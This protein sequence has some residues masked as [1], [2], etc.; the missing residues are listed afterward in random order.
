MKS[1]FSACLLWC[2]TTQ[3]KSDQ[4]QPRW[5]LN[6]RW[7]GRLLQDKRMFDSSLLDGPIHSGSLIE[8]LR[9]GR[10]GSHAMMMSQQRAMNKRPQYYWH[11]PL[12]HQM[13]SYIGNSHLG[14]RDWMDSPIL[15]TRDSAKSP[16]R[17][18]FGSRLHASNPDVPLIHKL[19]SITFGKRFKVPL[20]DLDLR[21]KR[22]AP[23]E[24]KSEGIK[25]VENESDKRKYE[26]Y[27][28]L[29]LLFHR[30]FYA[31]NPLPIETN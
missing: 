25:N 15:H 16:M 8:M 22:S 23:A 2:L 14:K 31:K 11:G 1:I 29:Q 27:P 21:K 28:V 5:L 19:Q 6:Y 30:P 26:N 24:K 10:S 9:G 13:H 7:P 18:M 4:I 17:M 12:L 3:L 20:Q